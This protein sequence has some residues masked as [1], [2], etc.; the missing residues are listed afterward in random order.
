MHLAQDND[1]VYTLTPDRSDQ[2]FGK[3]VLPGR[4]CC[5]RLTA[6]VTLHQIGTFHATNSGGNICSQSFSLIFGS[7]SGTHAVSNR[8]PHFVQ[9]HRLTT[10]PSPTNSDLSGAIGASPHLT[11]F[12]VMAILPCLFLFSVSR[13]SVFAFLQSR[14]QCV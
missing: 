2:P 7:L 8:S 4:G 13:V 11:H 5:G 3:A 9:V 14:L 6:E 12:I 10:N 1:V